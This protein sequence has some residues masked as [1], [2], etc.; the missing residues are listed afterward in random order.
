MTS[1]RILSRLAGA[2]MLIAASPT[3]A[4]STPPAPEPG[5]AQRVLNLQYQSTRRELP[6]PPISGADADRV[7]EIYANGMRPPGPGL[8]SGRA[9]GSVGTSSG[10]AGMGR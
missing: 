3:M 1:T 4:D 10:T 8:G 6:A 9:G 2:A 5:A 7:M